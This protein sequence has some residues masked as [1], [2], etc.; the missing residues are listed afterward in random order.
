[1]AEKIV[2][3]CL[4]LVFQALVSFIE[5]EPREDDCYICH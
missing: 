3:L 2:G 5:S 1:M 4:F